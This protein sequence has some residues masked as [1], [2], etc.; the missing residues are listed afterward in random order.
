MFV[1]NPLKPNEV[2]ILKI[3]KTDG[4]QEPAKK[5]LSEK[6]NRLAN[7][8][9]VLGASEDAEILFRYINVE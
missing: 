3:I 4:K 7:S 5:A 1:P 8:L 2:Q 9:E 6:D